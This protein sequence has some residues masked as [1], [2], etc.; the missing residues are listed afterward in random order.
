MKKTLTEAVA[1]GKIMSRK[2]LF[3]HKK[4]LF[5]DHAFNG[6]APMIAYPTHSRK[7]HAGFQTHVIG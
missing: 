5:D 3:Q 2:Q 4:P 7:V 1:F 6:P